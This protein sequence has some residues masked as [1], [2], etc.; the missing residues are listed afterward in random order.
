MKKKLF[1]IPLL[2]LTIS[3]EKEMDINISDN[4][5]S[6]PLSITARSAGDGKNDLLGYG[7]N[8]LYAL[9][10]NYRGALNRVIDIEA[11]ESGTPIAPSG[12][13]DN[14]IPNGK[15]ETA[16]SHGDFTQD[17]TYGSTLNEFYEKRYNKIIASTD[18]LLE[19]GK[20]ELTT[21]F[22]TQIEG[23]NTYSFYKVELCKNVK[24]VYFSTFNKDRLKYFLTED[25]RYALHKYNAKEI[26]DDFGT[27]VLTD[28][29]IGGKL[30]V[31][32]SAIENDKTKADLIGFTSDILSK[33]KTNS[34]DSTRVRQNLKNASFTL[35]QHGG[36]NIQTIK[37]VITDNGYISA[38]IFNWDDWAN[39]VNESSSTI[40]QTNLKTAIPIWEFIDDKILKQ[41]VIE[42]IMKRSGIYNKTFEI[43]TS[44]SFTL[45]QTAATQHGN[46]VT[47]NY[48]SNFNLI[49]LD[50]YDTWK[51]SIPI[52]ADNAISG[53]MINNTLKLNESNIL[54]GYEGILEV[55]G[56]K[57]Y[58]ELEKNRFTGLLYD[59][60]YPNKARFCTMFSDFLP[61]NYF[62]DTII[63]YLILTNSKGQSKRVP[64]TFTF[65]RH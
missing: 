50:T 41:E 48:I 13:P 65:N 11:F 19:W 21:E 16:L 14:S 40:I 64:I 37:K 4:D 46:W 34:K 18:D 15:I 29:Y 12:W 26:V 38:D 57:I 2:L 62:K 6:T 25:F 17:E 22:D 63:Q 47:H 31:L 45:T 35:I 20:I 58:I 39:S 8:C 32:V 3:C 53:Y 10:D 56:S 51:I 27:H 52:G 7:Y 5:P 30:S 55:K 1:A 24:R 42:E 28:I 43:I 36:S 23:K 61:E 44:P 33:I 9:G 49:T 59:R 60:Q 54:T